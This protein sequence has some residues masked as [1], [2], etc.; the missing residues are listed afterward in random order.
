MLTIC[1]ACSDD[2]SNK[3]WSYLRK[4]MTFFH[5]VKWLHLSI[6][7]PKC[8]FSMHSNFPHNFEFAN[9]DGL[10]RDFYEVICIHVVYWKESN[11]T[12]MI[13]IYSHINMRQ[14][15]FYSIRMP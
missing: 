15:N 14:L 6:D 8:S 7:P 5:Q 1:S 9:A 10:R 2:S 11:I 4:S 12:T 3:C 13:G